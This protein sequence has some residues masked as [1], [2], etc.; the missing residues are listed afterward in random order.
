MPAKGGQYDRQCISRDVSIL[1]VGI[2]I[3]YRYLRVTTLQGNQIFNKE[4]K[5]RKI[6][7]ISTPI[8]CEMFF[9]ILILLRIQSFNIYK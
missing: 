9:E 8:D 4:I 2:S 5:P 1:Q 6:F 3:C 7:T